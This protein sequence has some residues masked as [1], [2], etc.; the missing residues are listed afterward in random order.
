MWKHAENELVL[1]LGGRVDQVPEPIDQLL[2]GRTGVGLSADAAEDL[3]RLEGQ[4]RALVARLV[5]KTEEAELAVGAARREVDAADEG[6][7]LASPPSVRCCGLRA[8]AGD[9]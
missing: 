9:Q 5:V 3:Q 6:T 7:G 4:L 8:G 1:R 2:I